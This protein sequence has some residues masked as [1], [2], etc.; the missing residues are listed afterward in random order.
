MLKEDLYTALL[1]YMCENYDYSL[2]ATDLDAK[3]ISFMQRTL[4]SV[5]TTAGQNRTHLLKIALF[6]FFN[7]IFQKIFVYEDEER[8][9]IVK[10]FDIGALNEEQ[11]RQIHS[12]RLE[13]LEYKAKVLEAFEKNLIYMFDQN[14]RNRFELALISL[15]DRPIKEILR[16]QIELVFDLE[17]KDV[18]IFLNSRIFI[19]KFLHVELKQPRQDYKVSLIRDT[20]FTNSFIHELKEKL[21]Y[22]FET[23]F[24]FVQQDKNSF[25]VNHQA[26]FLSI[27]KNVVKN[28]FINCSEEEVLEYAN[29]AF[30]YF[31][32]H[33]LY[34]SAVWL[35]KRVYENDLKAINFLKSYS[36]GI[37]PNQEK[38]K[39][40]KF[41]LIGE[42]GV[43]YNFQ[44]ISNILKKK[45]LFYS[46]MNHKKLE[47]A[48]IQERL[49]NSLKIVH[50][51]EDEMK[52]LQK[53]R[54]ELLRAIEKVEDEIMQNLRTNI[55]RS[56]ETD[57]LEFAKRDLLE[58]FKQGEIRIKTQSNILQNTNIELE[59]WQ[60]KRVLCDNQKFEI[61]QEY[62]HLSSK[63]Q[64]VCEILALAL[65]KEPLEI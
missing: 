26:R 56:V 45:E 65:G 2:Y 17:K 43:I 34:E 19:K 10:Y 51:S 4:A 32:E 31:K 8:L 15:V 33:M 59:K 18:V 38:I 46:K 22:S 57:R 37:K 7:A 50:R 35:L 21:R 30:K 3:H 5:P 53:R 24:N 52:N 23:T 14:L 39:I 27:V 49:K 29:I 25:Y 48:K 42:D 47:I 64:Q 11:D 62:D 20:R 63:Y 58:A 41:P 55:Q 28:S 9:K 16:A 40:D 6:D 61:Q 12:L 1:E 13:L 60:A 36:E 54:L 44:S